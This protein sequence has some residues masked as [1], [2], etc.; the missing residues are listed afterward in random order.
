MNLKER[1]MHTALEI[2]SRHGLAA[3]TRNAIA[4]R[5]GC[6]TGS[7]SFHYGESRKLTRAIVEAAIERRVLAVIG[8]AIAE[9]HPSIAK[10]DA[11]LRANGLR[12]WLEA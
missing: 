5:V 11:D 8:A 12:A 9:R 3:T 4:A 1:I 6:S 2:A 7:V 10:V